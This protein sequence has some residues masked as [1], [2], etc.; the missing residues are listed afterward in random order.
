MENTQASTSAFDLKTVPFLLEK[1]TEETKPHWGKMSAQHMLEHLG[2][3]LVIVRSKQELPTITPE[4]Q[5]PAYHKFLMSDKPFARDIPNQF[6]GSAPPALRFENL[7]T[8]KTKVLAALESFHKFFAENP[9]AR[10]VHPFFGKLNH[11]EWLQF[12]RKHF[13]HHFTQFGLI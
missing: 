2:N 7:E 5:L 13:Q 4:D 8:A 10:P 6:I 1:L 3:T 9:E 12:Q 11:E